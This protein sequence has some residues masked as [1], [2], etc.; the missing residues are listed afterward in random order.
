MAQSRIIP[1][2][3][4]QPG[5]YEYELNQLPGNSEGAKLIFTRES[6]PSGLCAHI[7]TWMSRDNGA[8]WLHVMGGDLH[9]GTIYNKDGSI[10]AE[11]YMLWTWPGE[12]GPNGRVILRGSDVKFTAIV[13]QAM[14][15]EITIRSITS[16]AG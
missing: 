6:W 9:G 10:A 15:T 5:N 16:T 2:T 14:Q 7:N 11:S 12:A 8:T 4:Y 13:Y 3:L 1:S